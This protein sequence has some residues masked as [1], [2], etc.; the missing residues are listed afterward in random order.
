M[1]SGY[2]YGEFMD[3]ML[4]AQERLGDIEGIIMT[5]ET[6][7]EIWPELDVDRLPID[8]ETAPISWITTPGGMSIIARKV[9]Q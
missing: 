7:K 5:V 9:R 4:K 2:R 6:A 3:L 8:D 1:S